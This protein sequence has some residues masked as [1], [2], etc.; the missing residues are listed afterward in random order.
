MDCAEITIEADS[1]LEVLLEERGI[2]T[3]NVKRTIAS[4]EETGNVFIHSVTGHCLAYFRA[5]A[6]TYWVEY[7]RKGDS[8]RVLTAYSHRM[9]ARCGPV[10]STG[11]KKAT[12]WVCRE[13]GVSVEAARV[14]L[15]YLDETFAADIPACPSC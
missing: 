15:T 11:P 9:E 10:T 2:G 5:S 6:V 8:Y 3:E 7:V 13:C 4:A 1:V 14:K 12:E